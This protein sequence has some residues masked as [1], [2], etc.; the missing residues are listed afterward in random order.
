M[1]V[2]F[3]LSFLLSEPEGNYTSSNE[4]FDPNAP[5]IEPFDILI[6]SERAGGSVGTSFCVIS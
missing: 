1:D 6:D 5:S 3:D 2:Y 4:P